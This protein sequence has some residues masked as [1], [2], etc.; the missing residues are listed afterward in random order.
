MLSVVPD[1]NVLV[2]SIISPSGTPGRIYA[3]WK[4]RD[5][6]FIT[7]PVIID[8]IVEVLRRPHI[9]DEFPIEEA[10]IQALRSLLKR[11]TVSA[12]GTLDLQV[13]E[14]DPEDNT[15]LAAAVEGR[16]DCIISGDR[17]LKTLGEY[18]SIS[19][20][21]PAEFVAQYHIP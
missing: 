20:L 13:V 8:K 7:S 16:A 2:S 4:R 19:I 12:P 17:H 10:D 9:I 14:E 1:V 5:L 11:R 6:V 15:I 21:S 3:A 18:Q